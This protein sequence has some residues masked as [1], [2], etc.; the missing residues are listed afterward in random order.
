MR[1]PFGPPHLTLKPPK[2]R[3]TKTQKT[4]TNKKQ[5]Q[6]KTKTNT[7]NIPTTKP[8]KSKQNRNKSNAKRKANTRNTNTPKPSKPKCTRINH[9]TKAQQTGQ[10]TSIL[11]LLELCQTKTQWHSSLKKKQT[12]NT[13]LPCSKTTHYVS[14]IFCFLFTCSVCFRKAVFLWKHYKIVFSEKKTQPFK[15]TVSETTFST[16]WRKTPFS[17]KTCHFRFW[18]TSAETTIFIVFPG[19]HCFGPKKIFG[20]NR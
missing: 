4:K 20:Q 13:L 6:N 5:S 15:N 9:P 10:K 14:S 1:W 7:K 12:K 3:K 19:L 18:A 8:K 16:M 2:K 11:T 17:K